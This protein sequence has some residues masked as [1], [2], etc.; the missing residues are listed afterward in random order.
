MIQYA[1][2]SVGNREFPAYWIA[3]FA[4]MTAGLEYL[5]RRNRLLRPGLDLADGIDHRAGGQSKG[6]LRYR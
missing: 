4:G 6:G 3:A 5:L 1:A 2:A